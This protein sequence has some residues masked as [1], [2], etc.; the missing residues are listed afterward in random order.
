MRMTGGFR[1]R[2]GR[3]LLRRR[4]VVSFC[5]ALA[6]VAAVAGLLTLVGA[7]DA[8][9][10]PWDQG[11]Q[12]GDGQVAP[13]AGGDWRPMQTCWR[14]DNPTQPLSAGGV[15]FGLDFDWPFCHEIEDADGDAAC[16]IDSAEGTVER[17]LFGIFLG[18]YQ[19]ILGDTGANVISLKAP[20][21]SGD[22]RE[23][24][25]VVFRRPFG[26]PDGPPSNNRFV[27]KDLGGAGFPNVGDVPG[28][29]N[30]SDG[31][32]DNHTR[33]YQSREHYLRDLY[34]SLVDSSG[35]TSGAWW[36]D[37]SN[38]R[39]VPAREVPRF[40]IR[41]QHPDHPMGGLMTDYAYVLQQQNYLNA[42]LL[43]NIRSYNA[44]GHRVIYKV[45]SKEAVLLH[46]QQVG[47][48]GAPS[49]TVHPHP[50]T[51]T[52]TGTIT[53]H[54][55]VYPSTIA[56]SYDYNPAPPRFGPTPTPF[57]TRLPPAADHPV[58]VPGRGDYEDGLDGTRPGSAAHSGF[59]ATA[60]VRRRFA[61]AGGD[62][63]PNGAAWFHWGAGA[64]AG[65]HVLRC[66]AC[67]D[68]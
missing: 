13:G 17:Y 30:A 6:A 34:Y 32:Y 19:R 26:D 41:W 62:Q 65:V 47:S 58:R 40:F 60:G 42:Q 59:P 55:V 7:V 5:V 8:G 1:G 54:R 46:G 63:R 24:E 12:Y 29:T 25:Y 50:S 16:V 39:R 28:V 68:V 66:F 56:L 27:P 14:F 20:D 23:G 57:I 45:Q 11:F 10:E 2:F 64:C 51:C 52:L 43:G 49:G 33:F 44:D 38:L 9:D 35:P 36:V 15:N 4:Y 21:G 48:C 61:Q 18:D 53:S 67:W 31:E 22:F 37:V 3:R